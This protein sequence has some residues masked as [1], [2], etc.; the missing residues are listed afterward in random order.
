MDV[1]SLA[2]TQEEADTKKNL[3]AVHL[4][5]RGAKTLHI[6]SPDTDVM[7]LAIRRFP[8]LTSDSGLF[9][10]LGL[11]RHFVGLRPIYQALGPLKASALP[12]LHSLS[13]TDVT[14]A[15]AG[16]GKLTWWKTFNSASHD[17]LQALSELGTSENVSPAMMHE[18]EAL[19]SSVL[20]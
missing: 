20:A 6:Y 8:L 18:L 12:G 19:V 3:H 1:P 17:V 2:N 13:G 15:F 11:S 9:L 7:V 14:G 16:K 10:G 4:A 5:A